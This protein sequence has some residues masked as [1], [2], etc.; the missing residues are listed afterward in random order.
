L[1][2][3][4]NFPLEKTN[5]IFQIFKENALLACLSLKEFYGLL[6]EIQLLN[7]F[8]HSSFIEE[9]CLNGKQKRIDE[10]YN[11]IDS[12]IGLVARL[13]LIWASNQESLLKIVYLISTENN[14]KNIDFLKNFE[15][16]FA[17]SGLLS[18]NSEE[19]KK[20]NPENLSGLSEI[21]GFFL[22]IFME[23]VY[24]FEFFFFFIFFFSKKDTKEN[25]K[26]IVQLISLSIPEFYFPFF[27]L[28]NKQKSF[29]IISG[30]MNS[31]LL[32][33]TKEEFTEILLSLYKISHEVMN[34][35]I[36]NSKKY[37]D[38]H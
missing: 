25:L 20:L 18:Q 10:I 37:L 28:I 38:S 8:I 26:K 31:F 12:E 27:P 7:H 14:K 1:I 19:F 9:L 15:L 6:G 5:R 2:F 22:R 32:N 36:F 3:F 33:K 29:E 4:S 13:I 30:F 16:F 34:F 23:S 11:E 35:I 21:F 17:I 24:N